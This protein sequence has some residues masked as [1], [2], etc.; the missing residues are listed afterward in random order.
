MPNVVIDRNTYP[1]TAAR[2]QMQ[3]VKQVFYRMDTRQLKHFF[4]TFSAL[5]GGC[6]AREYSRLMLVSLSVFHWADSFRFAETLGEITWGGKT[7]NTGYLGKGKVCISKQPLAFLDPAGNHVTDGRNAI[8]LL[9]YVRQ[10]ILVD[11][12]FLSQQI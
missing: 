10:I 4:I 6:Q 7:K 8:S 11:V 5:P 12:G 2:M 3:F 1:D 9:V